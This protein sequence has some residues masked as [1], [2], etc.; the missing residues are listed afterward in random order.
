MIKR[1]LSWDGYNDKF[2]IIPRRY[3]EKWMTLLEA[4]HDAS[5]DGYKNSEQLQ[6]A[7]SAKHSIPVKQRNDL[8]VIDYYH[9]LPS[10]GTGNISGCFPMHYSGFGPDGRGS[11]SC[12]GDQK[13]CDFV[14]QNLC[15]RHV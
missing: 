13:Q 1:C 11:C 15:A 2:V 9:W 4:Y 10:K 3:A 14:H 6:M 12:F 7:I 5:Y 8:P